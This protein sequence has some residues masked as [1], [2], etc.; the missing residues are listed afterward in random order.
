MPRRKT[1]TAAKRA[2]DKARKQVQNLFDTFKDPHAS[3]SYGRYMLRVDG[4]PYFS[5][6]DLARLHVKLLPFDVSGTSSESS[7]FKPWSLSELETHPVD[8][9][10]MEGDGLEMLEIGSGL[11]NDLDSAREIS[12]FIDSQF[13][14]V[15]RAN[16][17]PGSYETLSSY[18]KWCPVS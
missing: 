1:P 2:C 3:N 18:S 6:D 15:P 9:D 14:H 16:L 12:T 5:D 10:A 4:P 17:G 8:V 7:F 13:F 11:S